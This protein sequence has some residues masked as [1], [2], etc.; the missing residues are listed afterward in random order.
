MVKYSVN[1]VFS[2]HIHAH[3]RTT[4]VAFGKPTS[5]GPI[6]LTVGASG[7]QCCLTP[8]LSDTPEPWVAFR[9]GTHYGYG[10]FSI[11]NQTHAEWQWIPT[12]SSL[13]GTSW[14]VPYF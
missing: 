8:F 11:Y 1:V 4:A 14:W 5:T 3:M 13:G 6:H 7:R 10:Q 12:S 9:D 2:G